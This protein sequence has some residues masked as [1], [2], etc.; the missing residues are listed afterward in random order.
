MEPTV[1]GDIFSLAQEE[2]LKEFS[3]FEN[4]FSEFD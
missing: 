4:C 3:G 1:S 2:E